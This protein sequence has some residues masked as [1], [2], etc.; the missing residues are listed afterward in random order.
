MPTERPQLDLSIELV[1]LVDRGPETGAR[2]IAELDQ[3]DEKVKEYY[4]SLDS[5]LLRALN[6][7]LALVVLQRLVF[8]PKSGDTPFERRYSGAAR[9]QPLFDHPHGRMQLDKMAGQQQPS[10]HTE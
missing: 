4:S 2:I 9:L 6:D 1:D 8:T 5:E 10:A 3:F 7:L